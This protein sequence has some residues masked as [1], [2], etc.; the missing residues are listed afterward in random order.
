MNTRYDVVV[1]GAGPAGLMAGWVCARAGLSVLMVEKDKQVGWPV[2]CAEAVPGRSFEKIIRPR[3]AWIKTQVER[4]RLVAPGGR[5][6]DLKYHKAGYVLDRLRMEQDLA[7]E[8]KASGGELAC[9]CRAEN[10]NIKG[11]RFNTLS[12]VTNGNNVEHVTADIFIAAD[13]VEGTIARTAG[14]NNRY[15]LDETESLLQYQLAG[16]NIEKDMLEFYVG[17]N[18]APGAYAWVFPCGEDIA[19]V[20]LGM[21]CDSNGRLKVSA[22][23]EKF[24]KNRFGKALIVRKSGGTCPRYQGRRILARGNLLVVGDAARVLDSLSGAGI[25]NALLSGQIAAGAAIAFVKKEIKTIRELHDLYPRQFL[26]IKHHELTMYLKIKKFMVKLSDYE[27]DD[28]VQAL[29]E[30]FVEK[31][32]D[33]FNPVIIILGVIKKR[34]R[35]IKM[36]RHL[37]YK[38]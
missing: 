2:N 8:F 14:I 28:L 27:L 18:I 12:L 33:S 22:Y 6:F 3:P 26:D 1:I 36:A 23:L 9:A 31:N 37:F 25:V 35:L 16:V 11:E 24:I 7:E 10:I 13:G 17:N 15:S 34:P 19:N 20:G 38:R 29:D 21:Q 4:G 32:L 30:Y 5:Y